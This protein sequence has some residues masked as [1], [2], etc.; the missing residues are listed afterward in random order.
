MYLYT[1]VKFIDMKKI[2][3]ILLLAAVHCSLSLNAQVTVSG[4]LTYFNNSSTP[5]KNCMVYLMNGNDT[6]G[7]YTT[8]TTGEYFFA[9][10]QPGTYHVKVKCNIMFGGSGGAT[11]AL[12]ILRHF[13]GLPP[14]LTGLK[15]AAADV[16][17]SGYAGVADAL[18]IERRFV[19]QINSFP[20]GN[21][22]FENPAIQVLNTD[23]IQDI[24]GLCFGDVNGSYIPPS[25]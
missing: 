25:Y 1:L 15:L 9:N 7:M 2:A 6:I 24:K 18:M 8:G 19:G 14:L 21:W 10:V 4:K 17:A 12:M 23:I 13:V 22:I 16:D 5:L 3:F 11:D 20:S